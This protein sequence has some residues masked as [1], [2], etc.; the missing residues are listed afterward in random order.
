[1]YGTDELLMLDLIQTV[2]FLKYFLPLPLEFLFPLLV[3]RLNFLPI[4]NA[5]VF[6][7]YKVVRV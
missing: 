1:M 3:C 6:P 2:C 7:W 4:Y 5:G